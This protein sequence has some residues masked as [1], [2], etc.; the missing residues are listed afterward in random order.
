VLAP[1]LFKRHTVVEASTTQWLLTAGDNP[2]RLHSEASFA[3]RCGASPS[4][5]SSARPTATDSTSDTR[6]AIARCNLI[7]MGGLPTESRT[8][9][10]VD[11]RI[12]K[13]HAKLKATPCLKGYIARAVDRLLRDRQQVIN[14]TPIAA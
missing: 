4:P 8:R 12:A 3:A 7:A 6:A 10:Y 5:A 11:K 1:E 9:A 14:Q 13:G 2:E